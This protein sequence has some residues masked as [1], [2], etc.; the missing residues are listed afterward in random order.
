KSTRSYT[1]VRAHHRGAGEVFAL[2]SGEPPRAAQALQK[3]ALED[4]NLAARYE[5]RAEEPSRVAPKLGAEVTSRLAKL[6]PLAVLSD[7]QFV[8]V[9][10]DGVL[11]DPEVFRLAGDLAA[12]LA[13]APTAG[14][15]R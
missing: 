5:L 11:S 1:R 6:S 7:A 8:S 10:L 3:A 15:Y 14:P 9:I 13:A 2:Y 12:A 4:A